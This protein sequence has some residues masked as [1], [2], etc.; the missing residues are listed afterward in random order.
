VEDAAVEGNKRAKTSFEWAFA[1]EKTHE[2]L[3]REALASIGEA[4][5]SFDYYVCPV[6]GH[7]HKRNAPEKCPVCGA[8]GSKFEK[9][10]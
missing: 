8:P 10:S 9:I 5:E 4:Q 7:T 3:Y 6:C 2:E 1:V